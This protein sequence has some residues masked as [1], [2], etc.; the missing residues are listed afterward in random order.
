MIS[1]KDKE[2]SGIIIPF[3][4][5]I[6]DAMPMLDSLMQQSDA[7]LV[8]I[9]YRPFAGFYHQGFSLDRL[10][11]KFG[12]RYVWI[13][14][15]GNINHKEK[16]GP[17]VL[18]DPDVGLARLQKGLELG[19][20]LILMCACKY[21]EKCHRRMVCEKMENAEIVFPPTGDSSLLS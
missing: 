4:Y 15:L 12:N 20:T 3:G 11:A 16:I 17:I 19:Y 14:E 7:Y 8:D 2:M 6:P 10:L 9:R 21:Y 18:A 1:R 13:P 5:A